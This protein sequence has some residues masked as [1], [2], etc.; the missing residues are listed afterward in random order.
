[1][2]VMGI[3]LSVVIAL[4]LAGGVLAWEHLAPAWALGFGS[5]VDDAVA[6][7]QSWGVWGV[8]GSIAIMTAHSFLPF[9]A[10]VVALANGMVYGP[11]WGA[12]ITWVGA[13]VG[14]SAAF[15]LTRLLGRP[16]IRR[17]LPNRHQ[18]RLASWSRDQGVT[19]LL[20]SRLIPVIAFNLINYA[21]ALTEVSWWT[22]LWTT[23]VGILPLTILLATLGGQVLRLPFWGWPAV[24]LV[25]LLAWFVLAR[26]R[27]RKS[28][29]PN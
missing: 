5:S 3:L 18:R 23:G 29:K 12:A 2:K 27:R 28:G 24:G 17:F 16:F 19:A 11:L 7:I 22:F 1:M 9:P 4:L 20:I 8:L 21:A 25:A 10:E 6:V 13:M 14:A 15:G 26:W